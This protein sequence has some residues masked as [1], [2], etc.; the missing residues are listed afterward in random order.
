MMI[1]FSGG[2]YGGERRALAYNNSQ[3][4][5]WFTAYRNFE[6]D[7]TDEAPRSTTTNARTIIT[8]WTYYG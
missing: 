6:G 5:H 3:L 4:F 8:V 1:I 2:I 7:H